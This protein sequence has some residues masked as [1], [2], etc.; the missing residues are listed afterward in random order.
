MGR[1]KPRFPIGNFTIRTAPNKKGE[2]SIY[3]V[4][5]VDSITVAKTT[6]IK[7]LPSDWDEKKQMVRAKNRDAA[8]LTNLMKAL[9]DKV[10]AQIQTYNG[11]PITADV[12]KKI[13]SGECE[14]TS[15]TPSRIDFIEYAKNYNQQRYDVQKISYS[16]FYNADRYIDQFQRFVI[17][18]TG[19]AFISISKVSVDIIEKYKAYRLKKG[20]TKEGINKMLTPLF[21]AIQYAKDNELMSVQTAT[22]IAA[23]YMDLK[24]RKYKSE[25]EDAEIHYLDEN[26]LEKFISLYDLVTHDRT[27]E[28][29]DMFLFAFHAC[30]LRVSDIITL[31]WKHIDLDKKELSKNLYKGNVP[32]HTVP[33]TEPAIEILKRWKRKKYND[34]FVFNL[35]PSTF[36]LN[37]AASLDEKRKSKNRTLQMSLVAIGRKMNLPFNLT[38]HV[39]R[40][41]FAVLALNNNVSLHMIS[42]LLG[43]SSVLTTEKVYAE[44]LPK[45]ITEEVQSKLSFNKFAVGKK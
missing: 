37:D 8:R 9:K 27:R 19:E 44:F 14:N 10:D 41:T 4:Y 32:N 40:H 36:D 13:L 16:T 30:G 12:V 6:G 1:I 38:M 15:T 34:R 28:I 2:V 21:K 20:N 31:E 25:V 26:Q 23:S 5:N 3:L 43:H 7:I 22:A 39:A 29:M 42:K 18:T 33:L 17:E 11:G 35:L 45:T 24:D